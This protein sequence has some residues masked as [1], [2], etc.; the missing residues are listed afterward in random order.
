[1]YSQFSLWLPFSNGLAFQKQSFVTP[2]GVIQGKEPSMTI[3]ESG[4]SVVL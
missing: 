4:F 3:K 2:E 1:M